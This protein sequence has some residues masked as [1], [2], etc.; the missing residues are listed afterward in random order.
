MNRFSFTEIEKIETILAN[1]QL[2][3]LIEIKNPLG[4]N[5]STNDEDSIV[6]VIVVD[7]NSFSLA[8]RTLVECETRWYN[9]K[10]MSNIAVTIL[11]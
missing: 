11:K 5:S 7:Q 2:D 8:I 4:I 10:N 1:Q 6:V 3:P 9:C